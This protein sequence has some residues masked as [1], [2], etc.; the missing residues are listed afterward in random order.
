MTQ[1]KNPRKS[2]RSGHAVIETTLLA[3]W[4]FFLFIGAFDFGFYAYSLIS[5]EN[6]ARI[7]ALRMTSSYSFYE[8][9]LVDTA[10]LEFQACTDVRDELQGM[11]FDVA[12]AADCA[13]A[14]LIVQVQGFTDSENKPAMRVTVT[15]DTI[16]LFPIPGVLAGKMTITRIAEMRVF[17]DKVT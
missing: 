7:A 6:A 11:L 5:V 10:P 15:F 2:K 9:A 16:R 17:G 3:P 14:P 12:P 8:Q 13:A 1:V 4:I